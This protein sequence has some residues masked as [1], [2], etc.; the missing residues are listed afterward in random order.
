ME[1]LSVDEGH[2]G[3]YE[4]HSYAF[5]R[6]AGRMFVATRGKIALISEVLPD[7]IEPLAEALPAPLPPRSNR[8]F[9]G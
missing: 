9:G 2:L 1:V 3:H 5:F 4:P 7:G 6:E 8:G